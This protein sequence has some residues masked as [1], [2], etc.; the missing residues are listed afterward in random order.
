MRSDGYRISN[1]LKAKDYLLF[2]ESKRFIEIK[3]N[4][5]FL[6]KSCYQR[7]SKFIN[8]VN[9]TYNEYVTFNI[10]YRHW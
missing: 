3:L 7:K 1:F 4:P 10:F 5:G 6:R 2:W 9:N 8:K